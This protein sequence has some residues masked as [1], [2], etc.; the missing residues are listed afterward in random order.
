M[1]KPKMTVTPLTEAL[2]PR[3]PHCNADMLDAKFTLADLIDG[4]PATGFVH[5]DQDGYAHP[6]DYLEIDCRE[7]GKPVAVTFSQD[8]HY[9]WK[10]KLIAAR[11]KKDKE[12]LTGRPDAAMTDFFR[13]AL[14]AQIDAHVG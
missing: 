6:G 3:C 8:W 7:C 4:W 5:V 14:N 10:L 13:R 2:V 12:Y 9:G 11:T 1:T